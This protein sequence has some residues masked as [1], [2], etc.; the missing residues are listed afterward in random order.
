MPVKNNTISIIN[1]AQ[2][3]ILVIFEDRKSNSASEKKA[4]ANTV[5][6]TVRN[7][8][9][10]ASPLVENGQAST[11]TTS[12][13]SPGSALNRQAICQIDK[14]NFLL[15][16]GSSLTRQDMINIMLS[17][18]CQTG[19]NFDGGGSI[20]LLFKSKNSTSI[21]TIVGNGRALTEVGYF[22]E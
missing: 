14:N 5:I 17:A 8:F 9:T 10:F 7:T 11:V 16:T 22:S 13:P 12:M 19:T 21:E 6:G 2:K 18:K 15:I 3:K 1:I 20:A 4:W